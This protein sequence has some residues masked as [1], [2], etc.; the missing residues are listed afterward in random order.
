M[1]GQYCI[2]CYVET[3]TVATSVIIQFMS[4]HVYSTLKYS[5]QEL[6]GLVVELMFW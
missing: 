3:E 6:S 4:E 5:F 2:Q 1:A